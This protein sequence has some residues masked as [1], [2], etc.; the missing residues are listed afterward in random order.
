MAI[1]TKGTAQVEWS[2]P[3]QAFKAGFIEWNWTS[4]SSGKVT[5]VFDYDVGGTVTKVVT[6]P[7]GTTGAV[8]TSGHLITILDDSGTDIALTM[9]ALSSSATVA[10][11]PTVAGSATGWVQ[12]TWR[13]YL[14]FTLT[15]AGT[16]NIG[17]TTLYYV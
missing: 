15:G 9:G 2:A 3:S 16:A 8:P 4:N 6:N 17:K 5:K 14:T 1:A 11:Y 10:H 7:S 12:S 13:G